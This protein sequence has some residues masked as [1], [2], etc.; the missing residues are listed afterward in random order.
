MVDDWLEHTPKEVIAKNFG[1]NISVF[2]TLPT[3]DPYIL[4]GTFSNGT[5]KAGSGGTLS[6]DSS[7]VYHTLQHAPENVPGGGG[8]FYKI[9]STIFPISKTIAATFVTLKPGALRELHWHPNVS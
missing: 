1:V 9:D 3:S 6:G 5:V 8:T 4:N 7:F 2:N